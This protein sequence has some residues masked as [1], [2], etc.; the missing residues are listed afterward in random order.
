MLACIDNTVLEKILPSLIALIIGIL[1]VFVTLYTNRRQRE[2]SNSTIQKQIDSNK[3]TITKQIETSK[4]A[5]QLQFRQNVLSKNRQEW[6]N[7]LRDLVS[8]LHSKLLIHSIKKGITA[9]TLREIYEL[10][11][12][13]QLMLNDK[14]NQ[15]LIIV[16][17]DIKKVIVKGQLG[18]DVTDEVAKLS[19]AL[20]ETTRTILKTEWERVKKGE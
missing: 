5:A 8:K 18:N 13:T 10:V 15:S 12:K 6:I 9:E 4:E 3:E 17:N 2:A 16:L 19:N 7:T 20:M 11:T 1:T 14:D